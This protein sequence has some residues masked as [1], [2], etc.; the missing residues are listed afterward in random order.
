MKH[1]ETEWKLNA[2][3]EETKDGEFTR[4]VEKVITLTDENRNEMLLEHVFDGVDFVMEMFVEEH[5]DPSVIKGIAF[6]DERT[7]MLGGCGCKG[8]YCRA[9]WGWIYNAR[10]LSMRGHRGSLWTQLCPHG[11]NLNT[12]FDE[13]TGRFLRP[14]PYGMNNEEFYRFQREHWGDVSSK[15]GLQDF[16][17]ANLATAEGQKNNTWKVD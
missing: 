4:A 5:G 17:N 1:N 11:D 3:N 14:A 2:Q 10:D 8:E 15:N 9:A 7:I 13:E 16:M 12:Q 6:V